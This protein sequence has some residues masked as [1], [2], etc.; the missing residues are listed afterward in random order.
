VLD[1]NMKLWLQLHVHGENLYFSNA[2][3]LGFS[4][5]SYFS[6]SIDILN[7]VASLDLNV[8]NASFLCSKK[9]T[10]KNVLSNL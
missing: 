1:E 4:S 5:F 6:F 7:G 8:L 2:S 10:G 9:L 3:S